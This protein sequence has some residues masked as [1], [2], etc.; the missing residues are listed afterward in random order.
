[1]NFYPSASPNSPTLL[2]VDDEP[3]ALDAWAQLLSMHDFNVRTASNGK[4]AL[5]TARC[6]RPQLILTDLM[7]PEMDGLAL[8]RA[9]RTDAELALIPIILWSA[10]TR[11]PQG[12]DTPSMLFDRF[13]TKPVLLDTLIGVVQKMVCS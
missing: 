13:L 3:N 5:D 8:C 11:S 1:M 10:A 6:I 4:Q 9:I 2:I 12:E 7:M